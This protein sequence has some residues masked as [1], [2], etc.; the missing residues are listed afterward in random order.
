[1]RERLKLA[2][3]VTRAPFV[4]AV[5]IPTLLG[6]AVAWLQGA[7]HPG[8][9]LLTLLG[10]VCVN[11]GL[12]MSNDYFDH[13]S[14]TDEGNVE[15]TPF[16]GGSRAIQE[17]LL[18]PRQTLGYSLLFYGIGA[19]LGAYLAVE[20]GWAIAVLGLVGLFVAVFHNAPPFRLYSVA[21]GAGEL[22]AFLGCGPVVV[23]SAYYVQ[24]QR[25]TAEAL[26]VSIPVGLLTVAILYANEF[27]DCDADWAA[28]RKTIPVVLGRPRAVWGYLGLLGATYLVIVLGAA[29]RM[30]PPAALVGLATLPLACRA[31][32]GLRRFH[33]DTPA[34]VPTLAA[35]IRLHLSTG[36]LLSI[37]YVA[38]GLLW[39]R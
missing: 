37:G 16:S 14:G 20:R 32:A 33:D 31:A 1:M 13:L 19:G 15:L 29:S 9:F 26:W 12:N 36:L 39:P 10:A 21:P 34:L 3:R 11:L 24:V 8:Y 18:T 5:I 27:P 4:T 38:T 6:T 2:V 7:F 30:L 22:A 28:G 35:T 23:L 17:G 25:L